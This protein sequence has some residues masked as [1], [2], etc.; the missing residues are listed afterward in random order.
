MKTIATALILAAASITASAST[1]SDALSKVGAVGSPRLGL[2]YDY[3]N[4]NGNT[5]L[6][7]S[8]EATL[9][10]AQDTKVGTFDVAAVLRRVNAD[11]VGGDVSQG[12][13]VG[14]S[15]QGDLAGLGLKSRLAYGQINGIQKKAIGRLT[16]Q[17]GNGS[18]ASLAVEASRPVTE[19]ITGFVGYRF[20]HGLESDVPNQSRAYFG[21][22][23]KLNSTL[24]LRVGLTHDRQ[25]DRISN[26]VTTA[27]TYKF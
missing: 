11:N 27:V 13:E 6:K 16:G 7:S 5:A 14:Y 1:I 17:T 8:Q 22:D 10:I 4:A 26:G 21:T 3:A 9:S 23:I 25:N 2:S 20:R 24:G 19:N 15:L 18:Y 12:F